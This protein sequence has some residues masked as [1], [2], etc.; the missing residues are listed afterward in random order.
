MKAYELI[1]WLNEHHPQ[2]FAED[3]DNV[4]LLVGDDQKEI[5]HVFLALDL[6]EPVLD[7]AVA[8]GADI[9]LTHHPM[10]FSGIKK[11]NNHTFTGRKILRLIKEDIPYFAMH[12]NYDVMGMAEL[13]GKVL[14]LSEPE[15][16]E[17]TGSMQSESGEVP[18][19][20]GRVADLA[21]P[22]DLKSCAEMVKKA[23][24]LPNVKIFGEP[25]MQVHRLGVFPGSGKSA[26]SVSLEKGVDVLVT[27]DIDHHEGIDAVAQKMA[28][29]DAGHYG[30]EHIF[31]ADMEHFCREKFP[32]AEIRTAKIRQP[33]WVLT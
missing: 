29:I 1:E 5:S 25:D 19:G 17:V 26:I 16:L 20:I 33:F 4:G 32:E 13:A 18:V 8:S 2:K 22:M 30:V 7:E 3:W 28:V 27:G 10:I 24:D 15:V 6:T 14:E 11:I 21:Q 23:F 31:I 12:T 9:I